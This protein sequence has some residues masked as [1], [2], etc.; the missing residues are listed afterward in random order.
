MSTYKIKKILIK[1]KQEWEEKETDDD[2]HANKIDFKFSNIMRD[3]E[4]KVIN[5]Y[6]A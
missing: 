5:D 4:I 2:D 3:E 6:K 1:N